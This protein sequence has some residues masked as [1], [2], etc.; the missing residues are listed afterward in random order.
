MK[1]R[2]AQ[3]VRAPSQQQVAI[4]QRAVAVVGGG[5]APARG[6]DHL[7]LGRRQRSAAAAAAAA[8]SSDVP[9]TRSSPRRW[10]MSACAFHTT[11]RRPKLG[12][13]NLWRVTRALAA[14]PS[15][16]SERQ[17]QPAAS[18]GGTAVRRPC[19]GCTMSA[20]RDGSAFATGIAPHGPSPSRRR[21]STED[22]IAAV[23]AGDRTLL[24]RAITLIE[25]AH[26]G[27]RAQ[28]QAVLQELLP[29]TGAARGSASPACR[30]W[31]RAR[32]SMRSAHFDGARPQGRGAGGRPVS[33][34]TGGS[35]L[36]DKTRMGRL[37]VDP[38]AYV[39]PRRPAA[40]WAAWRG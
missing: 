11:T 6:Q 33:T 17:R 34:R 39:R 16:S 2:G 24:S 40:P 15:P 19:H 5:D 37:A 14:T 1:G 30:A 7:A 26:P 20:M 3:F 29:A 9:S 36:G 35:I 12:E 4:E 8:A 28:A 32:S 31:A 10:S 23:H 21:L 27:H 18:T 22:Y 38:N 13:E 25:S